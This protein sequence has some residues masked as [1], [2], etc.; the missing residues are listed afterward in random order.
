MEYLFQIILLQ[1]YSIEYQLS[2][3]GLF[4][5]HQN[6][7]AGSV[8]FK[9][10]K[11]ISKEVSLNRRSLVLIRAQGCPFFQKNVQ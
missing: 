6:F 9:Q 5:D 1:I 8:S 3:T 11:S 7:E 10:T 2:S 4:R